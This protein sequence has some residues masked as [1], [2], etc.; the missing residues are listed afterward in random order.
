MRLPSLGQLGLFL[1]DATMVA[2]A[3]L[4]AFLLRFDVHVPA[5]EIPSLLRSTPVVLALYLPCFYAFGCYRVLWRYGGLQDIGR[6]VQAT[7][8]G[9]ALTQAVSLLVLHP[10]L[11]YPRS[12]PAIEMVFVFLFASGLRLGQQA[13]SESGLRH[14]SAGRVK[15]LLIIGAGQAASTILREM[16]ANH[17]LDYQLVGLLDDD[18]KK[19]RRSL[20]GVRVLGP[21]AKVG[22]FAR[23]L[24]VSELLIAIPTA[25]PAE[26]RQIVGLCQETGLPVKTMPAIGDIVTGRTSVSRLRN[27]EIEDLLGRETHEVDTESITRYVNG[28][29][30]LVTG[31]GGSIGA[32]IC[33]QLRELGPARV[34]LFGRGENSIYEIH[35]ELTLRQSDVALEQVIG[36]VANYGKL[37]RVFALYRPEVVFHAAAHKHVPLSELN[38]DEAVMTN[39]I[40]TANLLQV[41]SDYGAQRVICISTDKA[42]EPSSV[43]GAT[44][45]AMEQ[46]VMAYRGR[47]PIVAVVRFGN[48]LGSRGSV[49]PLFREQ[50]AR[51]G[52]VTVTDPRMTRFFMTVKEA[53]RL[54]L[55]AGSLASGGEIFVLDMGEPVRVADMARQMIRLSGLEPEKDVGIEY[56]GIRPGEK[57]HEGLVNEGERLAPT[58][59]AGIWLVESLCPPR[60]PSEEDLKRLRELVVAMDN[61]SLRAELR[62]LVPEY[63]AYRD[64]V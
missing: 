41:A 25:S 56:V 20:N 23:L 1:L 8:A 39:V 31:A 60:L 38:V 29:T 55:R 33:R 43:M 63:G 58:E 57:L 21:V 24:R 54:V 64:V 61:S 52:P 36:D 10:W 7:A 19:W 59:Q 48:V 9:F 15:R 50:I 5:K 2:A 11:A 51:G 13:S 27:V 14:K 4:L 32:E 35:K 44:K 3:H 62:R 45:R 6:V 53:A 47:G 30:V 46:L 16:R 28:A 34:L 49:V 37:E 12:V 26:F 17:R 42:V 40:G 18:P 22:H